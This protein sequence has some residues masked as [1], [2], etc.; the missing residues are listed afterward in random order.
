MGNSSINGGV[1]LEFHVFSGKIN[2][3]LSIA[4]FDYQRV[5]VYVS[6]DR[7]KCFQDVSSM[8][9]TSYVQ[10]SHLS[11]SFF[12]LLFIMPKIIPQSP[13]QYHLNV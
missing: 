3:G 12:G 9:F 5:T 11:A 7:E 2:G 13:S 4:M 10:V 6:K 1:S 8:I